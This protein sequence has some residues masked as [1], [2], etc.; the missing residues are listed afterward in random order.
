MGALSHIHTVDFIKD[1]LTIGTMRCGISSEL[2]IIGGMQ[3]LYGQLAGRESMQRG[4]QCWLGIGEVISQVLEG[5]QY[6]TEVWTAGKVGK[7]S[8]QDLRKAEIPSITF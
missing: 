7:E 1:F 6:L 8:L 3:A 5:F 2:S 4:P